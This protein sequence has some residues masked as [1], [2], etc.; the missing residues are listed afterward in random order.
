MAATGAI[1][2]LAMDDGK[3]LIL[4][5][6]TKT[7]WLGRIYQRVIGMLMLECSKARRPSS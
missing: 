4:I 3:E 5:T 7:G 2:W 6:E 1:E